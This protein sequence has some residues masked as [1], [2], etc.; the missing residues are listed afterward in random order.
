[1]CGTKAFTAC[2]EEKLLLAQYFHA[3]MAEMPGFEVGQIPKLSVTT[4]RYVP[5]S[6]DANGFN[7]KLLEAILKDGRVFL[8]S[9]NLEGKFTIRLAVL[10]FR[11]HLR[12]ID[13]A[14]EI[15]AEKTAE[16]LDS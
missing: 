12:T 15:I 5:K 13:L 11:S 2:L 9:T 10:A 16:I 4:F 8:S 7:K 14:L 1:L 3:K 6:G